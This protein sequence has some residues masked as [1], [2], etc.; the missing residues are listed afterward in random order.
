MSLTYCGN[1]V[2][3]AD[4]DRFLIS[5]L[6]PRTHRE[7]LWALYAFNA[8]IAKTR[9]VVTETT[10]GLI[11]LTWWREALVDIYNND[12]VRSHPV[13]EALADIIKTYDL[14]KNLF[15][16]LIYVREFDL[17]DV[18]PASVDGLKTYA[19]A[20]NA[21]LL[22]LGMNILGQNDTQEVI[23][24]VSMHFGVI[25]VIRSVLHMVS[26]RRCYLPDDILAKQNL[27]PQKLYDFNQ[28][29]KLPEIIKEVL[30]SLSENQNAR[31]SFLRAHTHV[32]HLY[33]RQ[34]QKVNYD[35]FDPRLSA[36]PP[37]MALRLWAVTR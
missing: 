14:D 26:E 27:S 28:K 1:L 17:E 7:A 16:N 11:R 22:T 29:E 2:R 37:F 18:P 10:T 3:Q 5:L 19:Q 30:E 21:P 20:T 4:P 6:M 35:L 8:E 13:V 36:P 23:K 24:T 32:S 33:L 12:T 9:S 25:G 34:L 15:L 31:S